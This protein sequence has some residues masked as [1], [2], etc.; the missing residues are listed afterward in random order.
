[1][2]CQGEPS[3][4]EKVQ[5]SFIAIS[6]V[7][8]VTPV[9]DAF[10]PVWLPFRSR[11]LKVLPK[12]S[13]SRRLSNFVHIIKVKS[14]LLCG[15]RSKIWMQS[16]IPEEEFQPRKSPSSKVCILVSLF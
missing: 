12:K 15:S 4:A 16:F 10:R 6:E 5:L 3:A 7:Y 11:F 8:D 1:M 9:C 14:V 2:F 13:I